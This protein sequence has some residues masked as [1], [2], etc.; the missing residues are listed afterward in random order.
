LQIVETNY[1]YVIITLPNVK[2]HPSPFVKGLK[3]AQDVLTMMA[4]QHIH[5]KT[6]V[7]L[8]LQPLLFIKPSTLSSC[9]TMV[10]V[11]ACQICNELVYLNDNWVASHNNP[12]HP[13]CL[14]MHIIS[15]K[16]SKFVNREVYHMDWCSSFGFSKLIREAFSLMTKV[17]DTKNLLN[18]QLTLA[19]Q[20]KQTCMKFKP[21]I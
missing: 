18:L 21:S 6:K 7:S 1:F 2:E 4:K 11:Q 8:H 12:S 10:N 15:S 14:M 16:K 17:E 13:C 9:I 20:I 3:L 19:H 5:V